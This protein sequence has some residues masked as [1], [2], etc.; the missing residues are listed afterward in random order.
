MAGGR[1]LARARTKARADAATQGESICRRLNRF[2]PAS[3][4]GPRVKVIR[5][6]GSTRITA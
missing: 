5:L 1:S 6:K 2:A 4:S 3:S